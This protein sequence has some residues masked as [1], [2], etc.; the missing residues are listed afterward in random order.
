MSREIVAMRVTLREVD[1]STRYSFH[2]ATTDAPQITCWSNNVS[3]TFCCL[4]I[5]NQY[6]NCSTTFIQ[7]S[8]TFLLLEERDTEAR[9]SSSREQRRVHHNQ[10][11]KRTRSW[12]EADETTWRHRHTIAR[13]RSTSWRTWV[14]SDCAGVEWRHAVVGR[15][16]TSSGGRDGEFARLHANCDLN[17][18]R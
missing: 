7:T 11:R 4:K 1:V 10:T 5:M 13:D 12:R 6:S 8:D 9:N 14:C 15:S 17:L 3:R 18:K 2:N 16:L